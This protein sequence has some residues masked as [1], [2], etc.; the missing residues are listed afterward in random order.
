M[1]K[2]L[3]VAL[4]CATML[5]MFSFSANAAEKAKPEV[6]SHRAA[7][8]VQGQLGS[9]LVNVYKYAPLT[10]IIDLGG[11]HIDN[12]SVRVI[13]KGDKG[14]DI[15]YDVKKS[16]ILTYNGIPVAGLYP[17][18]ANK[19]EVKYDLNGKTV[20]ETYTI[21]TSGIRTTT[22]DGLVRSWPIIEPI[23]V[24]KGYENRMYYYEN[25]IKT[26]ISGEVSWENGGALTWDFDPAHKFIADTK[27]ETRWYL[28]PEK[29]DGINDLKYRG[30]LHLYQVPNGN[31][32]WM[33]GQ[34]YGMMDMLGRMLWERP[35]PRGFVDGSHEVL[36]GANDKIFLRVAKKNYLRPDGKVVTTVRDHIIEVEAL[37]GNVTKVWDMGKILD[38]TRS[39]ALLSQNPA[40]V[41]MEIDLSKEG[42]KQE[43]EPNAPF[44][45]HA[46]VG[47]GRNWAHVNSIDY[48]PSDDSIIISIRQQS[49]VAKITRDDKVKWI[50]S[51]PDGWKG[52]LAKKV[53]KPV[54]KNGKAIICE[55][56][57]CEG[58]FDW[59]W[60]QHAA[61]LTGKGTMTVFDNG[62]GRGMEQPPMKTFNYSRAVEYKIDEKKGTVQQ[63]WEFGKELGYDYFST[64]VSTVKY[65]KDKNTHLIHFGSRHLFEKNDVSHPTLMEVSATDSK[66]VKVEMKMHHVAP[67]VISYR[68]HIMDF[69]KAF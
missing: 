62:D 39:T 46:G 12:V 50:L 58:D 53:L 69:N 61:F 31:L 5:C 22:A 33:K 49:A 43:I 1:K 37:T 51:S 15:K 54:D 18:Y 45:D 23:K 41:C 28:N 32:I 30:T 47:I 55:N 10:A 40:A 29:F 35:M 66:E 9:V 56:S 7:A 19:V 65:Q 59:T 38:P 36:L 42:T 8:K 48:D 6:K 20:I 57:K 27:G 13:G 34:S 2:K 17:D 63:V 16:S 4:G 52:E 60:A 24:S 68:A 67:G 26:A 11:K 25:D 14:I 64:V 21:V 3:V 44:G